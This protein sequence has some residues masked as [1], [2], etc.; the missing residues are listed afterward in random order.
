MSWHTHFNGRAI[1]Q[2]RKWNESR[3]GGSATDPNSGNRRR[4]ADG[5][6][7][8][9]ERPVG[10][11]RCGLRSHGLSQPGRQ[12]CDLV[13]ETPDLR[14]FGSLGASSR[15][16]IRSLAFLCTEIMRRAGQN[17]M[18]QK[19][20]MG[21]PGFLPSHSSQRL[22]GGR[23]GIPHLKSEMWGTQATSE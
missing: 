17:P 8:R 14:K 6:L 15:K 3:P 10:Q 2:R 13:T 9:H 18:S 12:S 4:Q 21:H 11:G 16:R 20:D 1:F 5:K 7:T 19:R 23:A 22:C